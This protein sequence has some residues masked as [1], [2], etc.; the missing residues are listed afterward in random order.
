MWNMIAHEDDCCSRF[1]SFEEVSLLHHR[2]DRMVEQKK[3]T[4]AGV[5]YDCIIIKSLLS[6]GSCYAAA[7]SHPVFD[8][9]LTGCTTTLRGTQYPPTL[10]AVVVQ[11]S[12]SVPKA[13]VCF[14]PSC[15][16]WGWFLTTLRLRLMAT[17]H[18]CFPPRYRGIEKQKQ[19]QKQRKKQRNTDHIKTTVNG[20]S[21]PVLSFSSPLGPHCQHWRQGRSTVPKIS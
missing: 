16:N 10:C 13:L 12:P 7:I 19:K 17:P 14:Q 3:E 15:G 9:P 18:R 4:D 20:K 8:G 6:T 21:T 11:I 5:E 1:W 2:P